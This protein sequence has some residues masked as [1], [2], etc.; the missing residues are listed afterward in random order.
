MSKRFK[1]SCPCCGSV[2]LSAAELRL[3]VSPRRSFY[4]FRCPRCEQAVRKPA[5]PRIIELLTDGGVLSVRVHA[6]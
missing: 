5:G 4:L 1:A 3:V 2:E 6:S